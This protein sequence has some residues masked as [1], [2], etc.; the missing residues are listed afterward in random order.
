[1]IKKILE[2]FKKESDKAEKEDE[3][4]E[5]SEAESGTMAKGPG[6][7]SGTMSKGQE[8]NQEK[9]KKEELIRHNV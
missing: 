7:Q 1:M 6:A 9:K 8:L 2:E 4:D 5:D 3:E